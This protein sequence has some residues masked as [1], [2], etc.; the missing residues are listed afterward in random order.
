MTHHGPPPEPTVDLAGTLHFR[1][2]TPGGCQITGRLYPAHTQR[3]L[4]AHRARQVEASQTADVYR[5]EA[6]ALRLTKRA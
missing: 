4:D 3:V 2:I 5:V 6:P 1:W